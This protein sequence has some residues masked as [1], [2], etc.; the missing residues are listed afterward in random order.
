VVLPLGPGLAPGP[1]GCRRGSGRR[2]SRASGAESGSDGHQYGFRNSFVFAVILEVI[3]QVTVAGAIPPAG[4][5]DADGH[6]ACAWPGGVG[7][8]WAMYRTDCLADT[9]G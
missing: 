7:W 1:G 5:C 3:E 2:S 9:A 4:A 8:G 6:R